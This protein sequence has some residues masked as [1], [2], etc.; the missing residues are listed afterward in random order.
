LADRPFFFAAPVERF[1]VERAVADRPVEAPSLLA[2]AER[3]LPDDVAA[4][5]VL[6]L[7]D[8]A[9]ALAVL[10]LLFFAVEDFARPPLDFAELERPADDRARTAAPEDDELP[11][12][13][14]VDELPS[15]VVQRPVS[16][17]CAASATA[18]AMIDPS[19]V[20]L[21]TAAVAALLALSAASRPASRILRRAAGLALIAAAA[22]ARPAASISRLIA[23]F[24]TLSTVDSSEFEV[25]FRLDLAMSTS[26]FR[27]KD[28]S[29]P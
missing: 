6:P 3:P 24:A 11:P 22:A 18:S 13:L 14:L 9:A 8:E 27:N 26:L 5:A 17:R 16:T 19:R 10:P 12:L 23:I 1:F 29:K 2:P 25:D 15:S 4:L 7:P 20:A 28:T 21:D